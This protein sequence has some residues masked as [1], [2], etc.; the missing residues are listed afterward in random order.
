[1][2][3]KNNWLCVRKSDIHSDRNITFLIV[4][5]DKAGCVCEV[6]EAELN[7]EKLPAQLIRPLNGKLQFLLDK[8]AANCLKKFT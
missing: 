4:G 7:S 1:M 8:K 2:T 3:Q 6:L 5:A